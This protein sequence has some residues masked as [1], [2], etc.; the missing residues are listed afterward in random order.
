MKKYRLIVI[1]SFLL[2]TVFLGRAQN[3]EQKQRLYPRVRTAFLEK[4]ETVK[5]L[6]HLVNVAFPP[7]QIYIRIFKYER[8]L[9]LWAAASD[10]FKL[11]TK[12]PFCTSSGTLGPK[13]RQ[14][15]YQIP[16]GFYY[17]DRF[18]PTSNFYLS[19]GLNYPNAS[20]KILGEKRNLGG[21]IFIHGNCVSIGCVPIS[22]D[23]IKELYTIAV[24]VKSNGQHKIPVD[25]YPYDFANTVTEEHIRSIGSYQAYLPFWDDL[26]KRH[27]FFEDNHKLPLFKV[28]PID[29]RY[30]I[31]LLG[32]N[33]N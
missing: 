11:V 9:E 3:F 7:K 13:R 30:I 18:N 24:K 17:I 26:K 28:N 2:I 8:Q 33:T 14:G 10:A 31:A 1:C 12:Y 22:D 16:E 29:G 4:E 32:S 25:I 15:D 6:F 23:K 5:K 21:D 20:D 19:L 27:H